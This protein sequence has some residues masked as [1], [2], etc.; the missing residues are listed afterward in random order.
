MTAEKN[1]NH[2]FFLLIS[3]R[4]ALFCKGFWGYSKMLWNYRLWQIR[5]KLSKLLLPVSCKIGS[6]TK[7]RVKHG[8]CLFV[9]NNLSI[10]SIKCHWLSLSDSSLL[11]VPSYAVPYQYPVPG[12]ATADPVTI[13][14]YIFS[15]ATAAFSLWRP[16]SMIELSAAA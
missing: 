5:A 2:S 13:F 11:P 3:P 4:N 12:K 6:K 7:F 1:F 16:A 14:L 15:S 9:L 8:L 10:L